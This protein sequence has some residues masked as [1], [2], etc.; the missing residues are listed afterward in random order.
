M[1]QEPLGKVTATYH[2]MLAHTTESMLMMAMNADEFHYHPDNM[3]DIGRRGTLTRYLRAECVNSDRAWLHKAT[4]SAGDVVTLDK[5]TQS[6][7]EKVRRP[8]KP[9]GRPPRASSAASSAEAKDESPTEESTPALKRR[10][11]LR[12][13]E[14]AIQQEGERAEKRIAQL[15]AEGKA[16]VARIRD[17]L[18]GIL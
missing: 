3:A 8:S 5:F 11:T 9:L 12:D 4:D 15:V 2:K 7:G 18:G 17:E 16:M 14:A 6:I 1:L 10:R 13:I